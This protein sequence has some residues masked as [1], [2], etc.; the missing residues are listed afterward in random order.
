MSLR[1]KN[2]ANARPSLA[3]L[4]GQSSIVFLVAALLFSSAAF[5]Q[6]PDEA[7]ST[8]DAGT[9]T[10]L[11]ARDALLRARQ[12][13]E[14]FFEQSAN[15]VCTE[16]VSQ[17]VLGKN[18]KPAYRE[19]SVFDYQLQ[20]NTNS[21]SLKL[22]ESRDTRKAAFR[23]SR[24]TLLITSGFASMLLII[25]PSYESSYSFEPAGEEV[26]DG[27]AFIKFN[28]KAVSGASSPAA[29]QLRGQNYPIPLSGTIWIGAQDGAVTKLS[30]A[31]DSSLSDIGLQGMHSEI[32]YATVRFHDPDES[33][34][35]P[36]SATIDVETP[37]QHW[38]N[39]HRFTQYKRFRAT[40]HVEGL[41]GKP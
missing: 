10:T 38:R 19:D 28:F 20:A 24:R 15:V 12:S 40:I 34:W 39:V 18:G 31:V 22:V 33:Y 32:H 8:P 16:S 7:K 17:I 4:Q 14:K 2:F 11:A 23:D 3:S 37:R 25:H 41:E 29:L 6:L 36:V 9:N 13:V 26:A 5:A 30:A 1:Y 35:M 27:V 21:G